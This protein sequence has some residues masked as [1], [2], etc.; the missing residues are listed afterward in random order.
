[1]KTYEISIMV[2]V[3]LMAVGA[4]IHAVNSA[5]ATSQPAAIEANK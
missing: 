1:M 4:A 3:I 2:F 5:C